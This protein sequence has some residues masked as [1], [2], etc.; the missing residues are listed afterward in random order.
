MTWFFNDL[1]NLDYTESCPLPDRIQLTLD[2]LQGNVSIQSLST[3]KAK[4]ADIDVF[5]DNSSAATLAEN[6]KKHGLRTG[7]QLINL[8]SAVWMSFATVFSN[9][10]TVQMAGSLSLRRSF[11][12]CAPLM[13]EAARPFTRSWLTATS[14]HPSISPCHPHSTTPSASSAAALMPDLTCESSSLALCPAIPIV[15]ASPYSTKGRVL[16]TWQWSSKSKI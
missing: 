8:T 2:L 1:L 4:Y 13:P 6:L 5:I 3:P 9:A 11:R 16:M 12:S 7:F 14:S 10:K 15:A